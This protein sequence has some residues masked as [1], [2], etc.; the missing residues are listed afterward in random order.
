MIGLLATA[1][2]GA[3]PRVDDPRLAAIRAKGRKAEM[4]GFDESV[5]EHFA[6]IGDAPRRF[7]EEALKVCEAVAAEYFKVFKQ[8][9]FELAWPA[10]K[11]VVVT[12][13]GPKSYAQFEGVFIDE[14]IGGH[15]DLEEN[16]LVM[17]NFLGPG[18]NPR[19]PVP[20]Q[21]NTLALV[22][23]TFHQLT[24]NTGLLDLKAD[25]PLV[26]SEG[27]ATYG[28]TWAPRG[29]H[30]IGEKNARRMLGL[31][32]GVK[33]GV[34][35]MPLA[36]LFADD[37]LL[38]SPGTVQVAYAESWLLVT[39]LL[40]DPSRLPGFRAYLA[41]LRQKPD[42]ARRVEIAAEHLGDLSRLDKEV[43]SGR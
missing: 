38:K 42:P 16:R 9:G 6:A 17:F 25:I 5:S 19:A 35:W 12:L 41:A 22:H 1:A 24:F 30:H 31:T 13:L 8:K 39:K 14:A 33:D 28:E 20:E 23:E 29:K 40:R 2:S 27:L 37:K 34:A 3:G 7:R 32:E 4:Q 10:E 11:Q 18:A 43:R 26:I 36:D 15:F 21:D